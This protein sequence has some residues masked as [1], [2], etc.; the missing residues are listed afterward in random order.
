MG[1]S[2]MPEFK[3]TINGSPNAFAANQ[4]VETS[5]RQAAANAQLAGKRKGTRRRSSRRSSRMSSRRHK[6]SKTKRIGGSVE[7]APLPTRGLPPGTQGL[8]VAT[9]QTYNQQAVNSK[10]DVNAFKMGGKRR[11]RKTRK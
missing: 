6:K 10:N 1:T 4:M 3:S 2:T 9:A 7:V 11:K 8:N 5:Q